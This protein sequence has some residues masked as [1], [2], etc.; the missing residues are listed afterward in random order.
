MKETEYEML[1]RSPPFFFGEDWKSAV[2][3]RMPFLLTA[4]GKDLEEFM[5]R[6]TM[7]RKN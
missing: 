6:E 5:N 3:D 1:E 2:D 7:L 4:S